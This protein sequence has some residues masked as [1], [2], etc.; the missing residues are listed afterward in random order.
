MEKET[1][2]ICQY[3]EK[4]DKGKCTLHKIEVCYND[5]GCKDFIEGKKG[6]KE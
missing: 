3:C 1:I 5:E 4:F 6:G 2:E